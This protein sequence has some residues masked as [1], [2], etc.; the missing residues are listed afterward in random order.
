MAADNHQASEAAFEQNISPTHP[1]LGINFSLSLCVGFD[2]VF[3]YSTKYSL[4]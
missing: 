4:I 1:S 3:T 2:D